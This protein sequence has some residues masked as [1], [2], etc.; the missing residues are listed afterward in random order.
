MNLII[1][2]ALEYRDRIK[3]FASGNKNVIIFLCFLLLP[4][5]ASGVIEFLIIL[6]SN[7]VTPENYIKS[8]YFSSIS[9]I[10]YVLF[11]LVNISFFPTA[12]KNSIVVSLVDKK[13]LF[14]CGI[15]FFIYSAFPMIIFFSLGF[16][17]GNANSL[18]YFSSMLFLIVSFAVIGFCLFELN[19]LCFI[20]VAAFF[21]LSASLR[22]GVLYNFIFTSAI[23]LIA[24]RLYLSSAS[25]HTIN[26]HNKL[27]S[28]GFFLSPYIINLR[29]HFHKNKTSSFIMLLSVLIIYILCES[30]FSQIPAKADYILLTYFSVVIYMCMLLFYNLS[31][32]E[33]NRF[34]YLFNFLSMQKFLFYNYLVSLFLFS[35]LIFAFC[36]F[37]VKSFSVIM[38]ISYIF[39]S[40]ILSF[41]SLLRTQYT[42]LIIL[43]VIVS[44]TCFFGVIYA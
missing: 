36:F 30:A 22:N 42:K 18:Y 38:F 8:F 28:S 16:F 41:I 2:D 24:F 37:V 19:L 29:Y 10:I 39:L 26:Q 33:M 7:I 23:L 1:A 35:I 9:L 20:L 25:C 4:A 6:S 17:S 11:Y 32:I 31:Y 13:T 3:K 27:F 15:I 40:V 34:S 44:F 12:R 14:L 21:I 43:C 5:K